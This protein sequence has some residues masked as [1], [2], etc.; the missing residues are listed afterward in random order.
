MKT[1][2]LSNAMSDYHK[3]K[4]ELIKSAEELLCGLD[5]L[6]IDELYRLGDYILYLNKEYGFRFFLHDLSTALE[7]RFPEIEK[8]FEDD[9]FKHL[10][11]PM[12]RETVN[13]VKKLYQESLPKGNKNETN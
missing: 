4:I 1:D 11:I 9:Y 12:Y 13:A 5:K 2:K 3:A 10:M 8:K 7:N 6:N